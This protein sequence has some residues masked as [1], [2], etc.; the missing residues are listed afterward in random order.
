MTGRAKRLSSVFY[1]RGELLEYIRPGTSFRKTHA[2]RTV[3][4]AEV[5]G[6]FVDPYGI[7]HIK[8]ELLIERPGRQGYRPGSRTMALKKFCETYGEHRVSARRER[9]AAA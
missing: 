7:P 8:F 1:K 4:T 3:E 2:D 5:A 6:L 9:S